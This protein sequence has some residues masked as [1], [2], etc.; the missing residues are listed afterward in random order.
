MTEEQIRDELDTLQ[1]RLFMHKM[2]D[3]YT[4]ADMEFER[5]MEERI[6]TYE[7]MLED[8]AVGNK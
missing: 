5:S 2:K 3:G 7:R 6:K 8:M 4:Q 1:S